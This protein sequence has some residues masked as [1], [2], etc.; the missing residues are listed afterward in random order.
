MGGGVDSGICKH[1]AAVWAKSLERE[2]KRNFPGTF[3]DSIRVGSECLELE[4]ATEVSWGKFV[5]KAGMDKEFKVVEIDNT[6]LEMEFKECQ[7]TG[8]MDPDK[9]LHRDE[10]AIRVSVSATCDERTVFAL[11]SGVAARAEAEPK[12]S[13]YFSAERTALTLLMDTM[14]H[15]QKDH[16]GHQNPLYVGLS[17]TVSDMFSW[18]SDID[19]QGMFAHMTE[20]FETKALGGR[21]VLKTDTMAPPSISYIQGKKSFTMAE[22]P[23][24]VRAVALPLAYIKRAAKPGDMM[25]LEESE[26]NL[27]PDN[28]LLLARL[29]ARL[30]AAGL[31]MVVSTHS[32]YFLEQLSHCVVGGAIR[33]E[34]SGTVLPHEECLGPDDVA[35][36]QFM[37]HD[38]N[39]EICP[40]D[41]TGDDI[42]Q[43]EF[44]AVDQK[45]YDELNKLWQADE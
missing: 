10:K 36:Y 29:V 20:N 35:A 32:P 25:I 17:G 22:T 31:R 7:Y 26:L 18:M 3:Y 4:V 44:T 33:N 1:A 15:G 40:L 39:Y 41:I 24:Y 19:D 37:P 21:I 23:S 38:G 43:T 13:V 16:T 6:N 11:K 28:Q 30:A 8:G 27:H 34:E 2:L 45:L 12:R 42:P 14:L 9:E 5:C